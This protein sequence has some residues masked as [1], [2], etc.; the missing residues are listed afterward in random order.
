MGTSS[1][2]KTHGELGQADQRRVEEDKEMLVRSIGK[3]TDDWNG[4]NLKALPVH[5]LKSLK[6]DAQREQRSLDHDKPID[7]VVLSGGAAAGENLIMYQGDPRRYEHMRTLAMNLSE[8]MTY[9]Q[10]QT[11]DSIHELNVTLR[12]Q[13]QQRAAEQ[14]RQD[15]A[16][17]QNPPSRGALSNMG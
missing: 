6:E 9:S 15:V 11:I 5:M 7:G 13:E 4:Y 1:D 14:Q 12:A 2:D 3:E 10:A 17:S 8:T 16:Q